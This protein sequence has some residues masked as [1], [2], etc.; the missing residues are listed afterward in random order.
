MPDEKKESPVSISQDGMTATV[1]I[2]IDLVV[3]KSGPDGKSGSD[4]LRKQGRPDWDVDARI[5]EEV[6]TIASRLLNDSF[7]AITAAHQAKILADR[8][9]AGKASVA[10][11]VVSL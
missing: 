4:A 10:K 9:E 3:V 6:H 5:Q 8:A 7:Q 1:M 2:T 11:G